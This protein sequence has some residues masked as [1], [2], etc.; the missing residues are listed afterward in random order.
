MAKKVDEE[1]A[2]PYERL[3]KDMIPFCRLFKGAEDEN[4]T[5]TESI[6]GWTLVPIPSSP[7]NADRDWETYL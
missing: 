4:W 2:D 1:L 7:L 5:N 6:N 3:I